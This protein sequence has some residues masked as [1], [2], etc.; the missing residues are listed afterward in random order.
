MLFQVSKSWYPTISLKWIQTKFLR[1]PLLYLHHYQVSIYRS[2]NVRK[3][4]GHVRLAKIQIRLRIRSV[5]P[6]SLLGAFRIAKN[7]T[8]LNAEHEDSDQIGRK[9]NL[10]RVFIGCTC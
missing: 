2:R 9:R 5:G 7:A 1:A 10:I 3:R 6:E 4:F 8:F